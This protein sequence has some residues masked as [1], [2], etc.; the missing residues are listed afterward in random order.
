MT[1][2][3][4]SPTASPKNVGQQLAQL[5]LLRPPQNLVQMSHLWPPVVSLYSCIVAWLFFSTISILYPCLQ[6]TQLL[7]LQPHQKHGTK[8]DI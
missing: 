6:L 5:S 3:T 8:S 2:P 4:T 1:D 7:H